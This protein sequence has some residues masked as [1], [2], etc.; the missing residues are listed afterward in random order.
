MERIYSTFAVLECNLSRHLTVRAFEDYRFHELPV[1]VFLANNFLQSLLSV[2]CRCLV[3]GSPASAAISKAMAT[4]TTTT[5][6]HEG[7]PVT[8]IIPPKLNNLEKKR[9]K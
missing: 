1:P 7:K 5:T 6:V 2:P 3:R 9:S 4:A 8:F